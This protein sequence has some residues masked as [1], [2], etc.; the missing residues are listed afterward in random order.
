MLASRQIALASSLPQNVSYRMARVSSVVG[1]SHNLCLTLDPFSIEAYL[2]N[3]DPDMRGF[4]VE[5]VGMGL[6][7][8][9]IATG[10]AES[11]DWFINGPGRRFAGLPFTGV[12]LG[13]VHN[14][15]SFNPALVDRWTGLSRWMILDGL[16]FWGSRMDWASFGLKGASFP[17]VTGDHQRIFDRGLGRSAWFE[18]GADVERVA[19]WVVSFH[20]SRQSD[21]A[22]GVGVAATFTGGVE[23]EDLVDLRKALPEHAADL[24]AGSANAAETRFGAGIETLYTDRACLALTGLTARA[25]HELASHTRSRVVGEG[26]GDLLHLHDALRRSLPA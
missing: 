10:E 4:A 19:A 13:H 20:P 5:G 3:L 12:G 9:E 16:G 25:C 23:A 21:V 26:I 8:R 15:H 24:A 7:T 1:L 11:L 18:N 6:F 17:G 14:R 22:L 2:A